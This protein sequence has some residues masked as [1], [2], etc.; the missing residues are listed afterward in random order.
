MH[1]TYYQSRRQKLILRYT[2][3]RIG[4]TGRLHNIIR[5]IRVSPQ[6]RERFLAYQGDDPESELE[7]LMVRQN[8]DTRW[9]STFERPQVRRA[10]GKFMD[11]A[12]EEYST[13]H[14]RAE[15]EAD[16]LEKADWTMLKMVHEILDRL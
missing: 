3:R 7:P 14:E 5:R 8:N 4:P 16:R 12:I 1:W 13:G 10:I 9:N 6:R 15:L 11:S 2:W